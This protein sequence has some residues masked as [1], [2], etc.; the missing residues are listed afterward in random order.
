MLDQF[1]G[2][3]D[4]RK[5]IESTTFSKITVTPE[6][7]F[8]FGKKGAPVGLYLTPF[9]RFTHMSFDQDYEYMPSNGVKQ[10]ANVKGKFNDFG[11]G[12]MLGAQ[13]ALGKND[14]LDW[15]IVDP[16]IGGMKAD[17]HGTDDM[18]DLTQ[19]DEEDREK[20]IESIDIPM[21]KIDATVGNNTID[22]K[23]TGPFAGVRAFGI[24]LGYGF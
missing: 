20:D 21:W 10:V 1:G 11:S 8:Y 7:R 19:Q 14:T 12:A 13:W 16:F 3:D 5:A 22:A 24:S 23:L 17:F 2:N 15:F 4:A 9:A 6:Y 18:S